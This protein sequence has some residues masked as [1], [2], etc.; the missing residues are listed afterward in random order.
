MGRAPKRDARLQSLRLCRLPLPPRLLP[1]H[2]HSPPSLALSHPPHDPLYYQ[3]LP[4]PFPCMST[5]AHTS[6]HPDAPVSALMGQSPLLPPTAASHARES[7][8]PP[9]KSP[10]QPPM[11]CCPC[12]NTHTHTLTHL[13][14][15]CCCRKGAGLVEA[16]LVVAQHKVHQP[17]VPAGD[18]MRVLVQVW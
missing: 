9:P 1:F 17:V 15:L 4:L 3:L 14:A 12:A 2:T 18:A 16:L 11:L 7:P 5:H 6:L 10:L 13:E 8:L